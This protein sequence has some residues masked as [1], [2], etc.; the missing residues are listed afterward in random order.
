MK[1]RSEKTSVSRVLRML[2]VIIF[3]LLSIIVSYFVAMKISHGY[4]ME[5]TLV[6]NLCTIILL[7]AFNAY[8]ISYLNSFYYSLS[9]PVFASGVAIVFTELLSLILR[10]R[11]IFSAFCAFVTAFM[12]FV[13]F[14]IFYFL[15]YR[16]FLYIW[17]KF[18]HS[19]IT[20]IIGAG[21]TGRRICNEF[22]TTEKEYLPVCFVDDDEKVIGDIIAG[23]RVFGPTNLI[24]E[25]VKRKKIDTIVFAIPSVSDS[26]K[27]RI[28]GYCNT[29]GCEIR[30]IPNFK[31]ISSEK[32][33]KPLLKKIDIDKLLDNENIEAS[34]EYVLNDVKNKVCMVTGAGG[35]IGSEICRQL[36]KY[37][38]GKIIILDSYENNAFELQQELAINSKNAKA[39]PIEIASV[40]DY[41]RMQSI[42]NKYK[43]DI[44]YHCAAHNH[45]P[46]M[47]H[48]PDEAI[49]NNCIGTYNVAKLCEI[50]GTEKMVLIST[51]KAISPSNVI[52]ATKRVAE[53]I[54]QCFVN[55]SRCVYTTV[56]FGNVLGSNG[57]VIPIFEK[58]IDNGQHIT[59]THPDIIRYFMSVSEA[60]SLVLKA[61]A[62]AVGGEIFG[63]D[64]G[65]PVKILTLAENL[66][67]MK[68]LE[69]YVDVPI[70]FS[71]LR[72]GE[73]LLEVPKTKEKTLP[74]DESKIFIYSDNV[75]NDVIKQKVLALVEAVKNHK[76]YDALNILQELIPDYIYN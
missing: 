60:V 66:I 44:V 15:C 11:L 39:V 61:S 12:C 35:S 26:D 17:Q 46:L 2:M 10:K 70:D 38:A 3:D 42:F 41:E 73:S 68:G 63:L 51:D 76:N 8:K 56:R 20:L 54:M 25:I 32:A 7:L 71:G 30:I 43:P 62:M 74:T 21:F 6:F 45:V 53:L 47:E 69:P 14:R 48:S 37:E 50:F 22:L 67:K 28:L 49:K 65:K 31:Q 13:A 52:G 19:K 5:Y 59:V 33:F 16:R 9:I 64:M 57:S 18:H 72:P 55:K 4:S 1:N 24:P 40:T 58:Q 27:R 36:L 23:V 75:D 29:T 34:C